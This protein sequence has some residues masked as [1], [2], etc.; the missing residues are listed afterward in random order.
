MLFIS[1]LGN[2]ISTPPMTSVRTIIN[3]YDKPSKP[4]YIP[5]KVSKTTKNMDY[6]VFYYNL[7]QDIMDPPFYAMAAYA[8]IK[9]I[10]EI[11][12]FIFRH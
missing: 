11:L 2:T 9:F 6:E 12:I 7:F 10:T 5:G 3:F 8:V 4:T 1:A